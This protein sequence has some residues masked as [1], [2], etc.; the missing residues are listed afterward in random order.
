MDI[1]EKWHA[2]IDTAH[3]EKMKAT[4]EKAFEAML[5]PDGLSNLIDTAT[6]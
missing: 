1:L 5:D 6:E 2:H 4:E 3:D